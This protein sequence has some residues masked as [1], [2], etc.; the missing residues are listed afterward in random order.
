[1]ASTRLIPPTK[2]GQTYRRVLLIVGVFAIIG[3]ADAARA[4]F[5]I[6][7]GAAAGSRSPNTDVVR[8]VLMLLSWCILASIAYD[9]WRRNVIPATWLGAVVVVLTW[10]LILL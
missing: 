1:M 5:W 9:G 8:T 6:G 3:I 2:S 7:L 10:A 4:L